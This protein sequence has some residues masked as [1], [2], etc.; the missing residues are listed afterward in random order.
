MEED[1][2]WTEVCTV[3]GAEVLAKIREIIHEGK[4]RR[5]TVR[6]AHGETLLRVPLWLGAAALLKNPKLLLVGALI[7]RDDPLTLVVEKEGPPPNPVRA[8]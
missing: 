6:D 7:S 1:R 8:H 3:D 5:I 2:T 4:A